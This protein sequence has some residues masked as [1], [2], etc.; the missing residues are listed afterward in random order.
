VRRSVLFLLALFVV[1]TTTEGFRSPAAAPA[2]AAPTSR[3]AGPV[4]DVV[5]AFGVL[6]S[7]LAGHVIDRTKAAN[8]EGSALVVLE[9]DTAGALGVDPRSVVEAIEASRVPVAVWVGPRRAKARSAGALIVAAAHISAIGPSARLGPVHP[10]ELSIDPDSAR[11]RAAR[12][13]ERSLARSLAGERGRA[14]PN[15]F[16]D[17]SLGAN[18]A[19]RAGA[20]DFVTPS[21]AQLLRLSDGKTVRTAAESVTLRIKKDEIALRFFK[22]GPIRGL[23]HTF[24]TTPA[25]VYICLLGGAMLV[26]FEVFQPGFGIA[27]GSGALLLAGAIFGMTVLPVGVWGVVM[28]SVGVALLTLDVAINELGPATFAGTAM[29]IVGSLRMFPAPG[30]ALGLPGWLVVVAA[31]AALVYYVPVMTLVRRSRRDPEEQRAARA[32]VG[33]PGKVRSM[34]NPEGFVWVADE[35]WRARSEDG[36]KVRVGE[37][38]V[39]TG[40]DG[41]LLRVKRP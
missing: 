38:V 39:V 4:V 23:L 37:M 15:A 31:V 19:L 11:G 24:A 36:S 7:Q 12:T 17:R 2:Q 3:A 29:L 14:D 1:G 27:G 10:A 40:A 28:F 18:E 26:S 25:L 22:P 16:L 35:L 33:T 9:L 13:A 20:V 8:R 6:D 34:L 32:L 30:G 21:V 41:M 5:E